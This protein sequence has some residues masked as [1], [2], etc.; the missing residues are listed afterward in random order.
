MTK[1]VG[2]FCGS[3][4]V[5][6]L[7]NWVAESLYHTGGGHGK[8]EHAAYVID[9]GEAEAEEEVVDEGPTFAD[10]YATADAAAGEKVWGK[11]RACHKLE[12]GA[13]GTGPHLYDVMGRQI[14]AVGEFGYSD[15]LA[16]LSDRA[17]TPEEMDA[18]LEDPK[19]YAP[20]NKMTFA[21]IRDI[22]DRA[23]LIAY[24]ETIGN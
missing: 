16:S 24:L 12:D 15:A 3:L 9:T 23:N 8:E 18:W 5:F 6:M 4:L 17:W 10:V 19:G 21:G 11:C 7:G 22:E 14:A 1:I 2:G 13:N 20:G